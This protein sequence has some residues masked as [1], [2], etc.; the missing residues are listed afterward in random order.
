MYAGLRAGGEYDL[1]FRPAFVLFNSGDEKFRADGIKY[2]HH[3]TEGI[4]YTKSGYLQYETLKDFKN[5]YREALLKS[6]R[7]IDFA[8]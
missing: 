1:T 3:L 4:V 5:A 6:G 8:E 2:H 7:N